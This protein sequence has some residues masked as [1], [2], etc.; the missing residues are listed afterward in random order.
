MVKH[1]LLSDS[2]MKLRIEI[3][4]DYF[5]DQPKNK[6]IDEMKTYVK[7]LARINKIF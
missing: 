6:L 3:L 4:S 2:I 5:Q 1:K 7:H